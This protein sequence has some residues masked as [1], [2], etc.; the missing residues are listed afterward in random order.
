LEEWLARREAGISSRAEKLG[1]KCGGCTLCCKLVSIETEELTKPADKWCESCVVGQGC[2]IYIDRPKACRTWTCQWLIDPFFGDHWFPAKSKMVVQFLPFFERAVPG[3]EGSL[4]EVLVD[5]GYP[6]RWR[7]EPWISDLRTLS[8]AG[9][10]RSLSVGHFKVCIVL[11]GNKRWI[12]LPNKDV[13]FGQGVIAKVG[14]DEWELLP[15]DNPIEA[16]RRMNE[17]AQWASGL[18]PAQRAQLL[19]ELGAHR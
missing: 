12:V 13:E 7:E 10:N 4:I 17:L 15:T 6:N 18:S 14:E 1:R 5:P 11:G 16:T 19:T 2:S 8:S 9:L 3:A